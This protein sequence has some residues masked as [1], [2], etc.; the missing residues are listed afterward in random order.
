[1]EVDEE[2]RVEL[3][4]G[5]GHFRRGHGMGRGKSPRFQLEYDYYKEGNKYH[6]HHLP[7]AREE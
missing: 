5:G 2:E 3:R 1:M 4:G 6:I 7:I